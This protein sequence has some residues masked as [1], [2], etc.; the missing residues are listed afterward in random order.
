MEDI[1]Q[2][3]EEQ[4]EQNP[5][6]EKVLDKVIEGISDRG[7]D[8]TSLN[9]QVDDELDKIKSDYEED[10]IQNINDATQDDTN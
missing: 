2:W 3:F 9:Q 10:F 6:W 8:S 5:E 4:K 7:F 1:I